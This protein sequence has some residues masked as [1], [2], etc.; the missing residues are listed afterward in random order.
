MVDITS[1]PGAAYDTLAGYLAEL[2][3]VVVSIIKWAIFL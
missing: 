1:I 3:K 2:V